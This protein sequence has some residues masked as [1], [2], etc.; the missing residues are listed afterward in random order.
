M[1]IVF[2][3]TN[4]RKK[5]DLQN[6]I[7]SLNLDIKVLGLDDISWDR[8]EIPE[9]GTTLEENS[10]EK[11]KAVWDFCQD[12]GLNMPIIT[13]DA[14]LFI[15]ALG[16]KPGIMT[17]RYADYELSLDSTLPKYECIN[18]VLREM[19]GQTNRDAYYK[20]VVTIMFADGSY[21]QEEGISNGSIAQKPTLPISKPY[22]YAIF[23][24]NGYNDTF[25]QIDGDELKATYRYIA[26]KKALKKLK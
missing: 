1:E 19:E 9:E 6:V 20:C 24:L 11:A 2:G 3:T 15:D 18:K 5:E 22:F 4:A 13:D 14:G 7:N 8:G 23:I 12:K 21:Y 16:G 25:S 26:L 10:W 17:S